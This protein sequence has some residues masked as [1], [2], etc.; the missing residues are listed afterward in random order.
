MYRVNVRGQSI[1]PN[2]D[3]GIFRSWSMDFSYLFGAA[4]GVKNYGLDVPITYP[5]EIPA[6]SAPE[7]VYNTAR[8]IGP[9][10]INK[11]YNLSWFFPI[12]SGFMY[13]VRLHFC[14]VD[15]KI[16]K[17]NQR[18][19]DIFINNQIVERGLD[20]IALRQRDG[21][22]LYRDYTLLIPKLNFLGKQDL[23]LE[24]HPNLQT[25]PQY[26]DAILNGVEIFKLSNNDGNLAGL[27]PPLNNESGIDGDEPSFSSRSSKSSK[28]EML[29]IASSS[30]IGALAISF[31]IYLVAFLLK[32]KIERTRKN[33]RNSSRYRSFSFSET[34]MATVTI[35][36]E[37]ELHKFDKD[38]ALSFSPSKYCIVPLIGYCKEDRKMILIYE[39]MPNGTLFEHLHFADQRQKP[40]LSWKYGTSG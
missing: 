16:T 36:R 3:T 9:P 33:T 10:E 13:L 30:V 4:F 6:Y 15:G 17:I 2:Q 24:L 20:I 21:I 11:N 29:I 27:N 8:S 37:Q 1:P 40:P 18:V 23:W 7:E 5:P 14:K 34:K 22:P 32:R 19:F 25:K 38:D 35:N 31:C 39:D 26:Y 12:D 28:K